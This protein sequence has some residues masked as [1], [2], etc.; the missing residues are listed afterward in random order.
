MSYVD[1]ADIAALEARCGRPREVALEAEFGE[2]AFQL[3]RH[4]MRHGRRHDVTL[5]IFDRPELDPARTRIVVIRKTV[6]PEG[7]FR[8]PSGGVER[9]EAFE[10]GA[11]REA[12]EETGLDCRLVR[13]LLRIEATFTNGPER[14]PWTTH[15]VAAVRTGGD[16]APRDTIEIAEAAFASRAEIRT[17]YRDRLLVTGSGGLRYRAALADLAL[18]EVERLEAAG[19]APWAPGATGKTGEESR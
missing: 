18:D 1:P 8:F 11:R 7:V 3:L 5:L 15:V 19:P 12:L 13:Y 2:A 17:T 14:E 10:A 4:S 9:G 6:Y 16:L